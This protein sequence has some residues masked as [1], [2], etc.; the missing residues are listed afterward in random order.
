L[1][2]AKFPSKNDSIGKAA[3]EYLAYL[4]AIESGIQMSSCIIE[5]IADKIGVSRSE[6]EIMRNA[7][8]C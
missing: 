6:K 3:W 4:L 1:W 2:I 8:R 7:F 5:K